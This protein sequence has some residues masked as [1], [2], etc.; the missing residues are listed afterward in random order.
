MVQLLLIP[1]DSLLFLYI[2]SVS[3]AKAMRTYETT[4]TQSVIE[5]WIIC[6]LSASKL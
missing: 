1:V 2:L 6:Y 4:R 3:N 5:E